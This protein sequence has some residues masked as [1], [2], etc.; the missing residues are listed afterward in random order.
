MLCPVD[1]GAN[2]LNLLVG[3]DSPTERHIGPVAQ[4]DRALLYE[5]NG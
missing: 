1:L 4:M 3:F 5:R 2:F